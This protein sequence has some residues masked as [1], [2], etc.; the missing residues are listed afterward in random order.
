M[1]DLRDACDELPTINTRGST[2][3]TGLAFVPDPDASI[4]GY[5]FNYSVN[6]VCFYQLEKR[7]TF[8]PL[9]VKATLTSMDWMV[10]NLVASRD[11]RVN[12]VPQTAE[13]QQT[14]IQEPATKEKQT[15]TTVCNLKNIVSS[16]I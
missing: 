10:L 2:Q 16:S 14:T 3:E 15:R 7:E 9:T 12:I 4:W 13:Q 1:G 5:V 11:L 6:E 8:G